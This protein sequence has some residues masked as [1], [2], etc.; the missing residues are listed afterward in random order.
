MKKKFI[1]CLVAFLLVNVYC[2]SQ[3][4]IERY[5]ELTESG[6][7]RKISINFG[8]PDLYIVDSTMAKC[9]TVIPQCKNIVD[10]LNYMGAQGWQLVTTSILAGYREFYLKKEFDKSVLAVEKSTP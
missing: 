6:A 9:I 5:C 7:F 3:N 4:K 10:A 8:S 1:G 2:F